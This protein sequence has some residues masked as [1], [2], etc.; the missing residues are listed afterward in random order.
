MS[1]FPSP[2]Q[3]KPKQTIFSRSGSGLDFKARRTGGIHNKTLQDTLWLGAV[4]GLLR[5]DH[6]SMEGLNVSIPHP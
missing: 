5:T 1:T 6:K 4:A 3:I 2:N